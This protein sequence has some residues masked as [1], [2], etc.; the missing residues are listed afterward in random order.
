MSLSKPLCPSCGSDDSKV[1]D[2][3]GDYRR[4]EC[5][6]CNERFSTTEVVRPPWQMRDHKHRIAHTLK[7][8]SL[9]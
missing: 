4:R 1:I 6:T 8:P 9:I 2:V 3:R 5:L 7:Q